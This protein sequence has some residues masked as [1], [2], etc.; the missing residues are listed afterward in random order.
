MRDQLGRQ[1][2]YLRLSVTD[3]CNE[4][5]L[6]C[7]PPEGVPL[8]GHDDLLSFDEIITI[9][10]EAADLGIRYLRLTGGEPLLRRGIVPLVRELKAIPGI[11]GIGLTTNGLLLGAMAKELAGAGLNSVNVSLDT[12]DRELYRRITRTGDLPEVLRGIEAALAAGLAVK[13]DC[14]VLGIPEQRLT[15]VAALAKDRPIHVRFIELMPI[16][17]GR[18]AFCPDD[19]LLDS[20]RYLPMAAVQETL[21]SLCGPLT[22]VTDSLGFGPAVYR[23]AEGYAGCFGFIAAVSHRFCDRCNRVRLTSRGFLKTCLQ[24]EAGEDLRAV[25]R[26]GHEPAVCRQRL[27]EAFE[28]ALREKPA[29][30]HFS[31]NDVPAGTDEAPADETAGMSAIGG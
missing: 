16:G 14:V 25:L 12:C 31:E 11:E 20:C 13:I 30:H 29:A 1:I 18:R 22:P 28:K 8:V 24:Y 21:E 7:M 19:D 6:Y 15:D 10:R 2:D 4:R 9:V 26:A 17:E 23:R 27:R 3:R 5:C